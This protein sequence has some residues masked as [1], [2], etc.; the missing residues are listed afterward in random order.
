MPTAVPSMAGC[1]FIDL[2][3]IADSRGALSFAES[4]N[5]V[6]FD[7][8]RVFYMYD[9]PPGSKRGAHAHYAASV[10][11]F[12]LAGSCDAILD[13][14]RRRESVRLE[15]PNRGLLVGPRIWHELENF[16]AHSVC[17]VLTSHR[18]DEADYMRDYQAFRREV[19]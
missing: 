14:R 12:M 9:L 16:A 10:L 2:P 5:H 4:G 15:Q 8:A 18:Y 19:L 1:R 6:P 7:I 17:L 13:D 3:K 11:I